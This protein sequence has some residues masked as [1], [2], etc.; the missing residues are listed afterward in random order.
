[1]L[2]LTKVYKLLLP[3]FLSNVL[4]L[5]QDPIWHTK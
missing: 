3:W 5:F 1:M 4:F 2:L